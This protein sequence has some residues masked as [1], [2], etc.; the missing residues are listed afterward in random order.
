[1][2]LLKKG[3]AAAAAALA[4]G[5]ALLVAEVMVARDGPA[6]PPVPKPPIDAAAGPPPAPGTVPVSV[7][8]L[9]DSTAAGDGTSRPDEILPEQTAALLGQPVRLTDLA[10]SGDRA[11]DVLRNQLPRVASYQ[12][13]TVFISMGANDVTH[14][15]RRDAFRR[16]YARVLAGLPAVVRTV[17]MLG[18]PD[19]GASPR[20]PQPLRAVA[21]WRGR[22]LN[23]DVAH[24]AARTP[25]AVYVDIAAR[26]GPP[27]RENP[28]RY[29]ASDRYHPNEA[30]YALWAKAIAEALN[31]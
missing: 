25:H 12:P 2:S 17:V 5:A 30:G 13:G 15:T 7:V 27:F 18:V 20:L 9:G 29:F 28:P 19:M 10:H 16:D 3:L 24:L 4:S 31:R 11:A 22:L 8:W 23:A 1:V 6:G 14:L 26:T 21:G